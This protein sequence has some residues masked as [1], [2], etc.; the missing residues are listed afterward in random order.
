MTS[1]VIAPLPW[2]GYIID[3]W[4]E[5][6]VAMNIA[7]AGLLVLVGIINTLPVIG[8]VS[9]ARLGK[10]YGVSWTDPTTILLL[11]HRAVLFGIIGVFILYS[12]VMPGLQPL[13]MLAA[14]IAM[15][16]FLLLG[17][18][19]DSRLKTIVLM[20]WIGLVALALAAALRAVQAT[21]P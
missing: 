20:D 6:T 9:A 11:R 2:A 10:L 3:T 8:C 4:Q 18:G 17:S 14:G 19:S 7:I 21:L 15:G 12:A 13:A 5:R 16:S 1:E